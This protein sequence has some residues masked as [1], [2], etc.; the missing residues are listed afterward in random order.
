MVLGNTLGNAIEQMAESKVIGGD[1]NGHHPGWGCPKAV[2][3]GNVLAELLEEK[4]LN[5]D[6]Y[7]SDHHLVQVTMAS[8]TRTPESTRRSR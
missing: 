1:F 4:D 6:L 3:R 8:N 5:P 2:R 7:G